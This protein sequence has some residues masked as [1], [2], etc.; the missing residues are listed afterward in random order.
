M[1]VKSLTSFGN[2]TRAAQECREVTA[3]RREDHPD[4]LPHGP[5]ESE[6][7]MIV[8]EGHLEAFR[9]SG[10]EITAQWQ[11][12]CWPMAPRVIE[13]MSRADVVQP[14]EELNRVLCR[15]GLVARGAT[16][17][18][19]FSL[20][21]GESA[22]P[23]FHSEFQSVAWLR[24][25]QRREVRASRNPLVHLSH[26]L[27][28][29]RIEDP[30][31]AQPIRRA[32]VKRALRTR[33]WGPI[34]ELW[35]SWAKDPDIAELLREQGVAVDDDSRTQY[36]PEGNVQ[37]RVRERLPA[38]NRQTVFRFDIPDIPDEALD[39]HVAKRLLRR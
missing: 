34:E 3:P 17:T 18:L 4:N 13:R 31:L 8:I 1:V 26:L 36:R 38:I 16:Y 25:R 19:S 15:T 30:W 23:Y 11:N 28:W 14:L 32:E 6:P 29:N 2:L 39:A 21:R 9:D 33:A 20:P 5:H 35:K 24:E 27:G 37:E 12:Y 10:S 22:E 7:A